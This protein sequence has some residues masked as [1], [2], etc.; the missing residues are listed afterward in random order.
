MDA[1]RILR[2]HI[3]G[4]GHDTDFAELMAAIDGTGSAIQHELGV[5]AE[6]L[7]ELRRQARAEPQRRKRDASRYALG[8]ALTILGL[9][10]LDPIALTGLFGNPARMLTWLGDARSA[11]GDAPL[12]E[13]IGAVFED[14]ARFEWCRKWGVHIGWLHGKVLYDATVTSFVISGRAGPKERWRRAEI[15]EDQ[16]SL[17]LR[18]CL[19]ER[20]DV[21]VLANRG[22]AFEWI[23][24]NG[25]NPTWWAP[26]TIPPE[27]NA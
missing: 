26:P 3:V 15:T 12:V 4:M 10:H 6:T 24:A 21:P 19:Y 14:D 22:E 16:E 11:L 5:M 8:G 25:G 2:G 23:H 27:W 1:P 20:I 9:E 7:P 18:I 17:I 13:L